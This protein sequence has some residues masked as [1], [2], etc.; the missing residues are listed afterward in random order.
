MQ[1]KSFRVKGEAIRVRE[2]S[3]E[4]VAEKEVIGLKTERQSLRLAL[5]T[6]RQSACLAPAKPW[7]ESS[8]LKRLF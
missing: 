1:A 3:A 6:E 5:R 2:T 7:D 4:L 8:A